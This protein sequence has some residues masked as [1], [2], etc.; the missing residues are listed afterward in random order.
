VGRVLGVESRAAICAGMV[1]SS[2]ER[3]D[4]GLRGED[5]RGRDHWTGL[6]TMGSNVGLRFTGR[7]LK[8][9]GLTGNGGRGI[10]RAV[11]VAVAVSVSVDLAFKLE[12]A[13]GTLKRGAMVRES[14]RTRGRSGRDTGSDTGRNA[15]C[16]GSG[17]GA[18]GDVDVDVGVSV[19]IGVGSA[20]S[21]GDWLST[22]N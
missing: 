16:S 11:A 5:T 22:G 21:A 9:S 2:G 14:F 17:S 20:D 6:K 18:G 19:G 1:E 8:L 3:V 12:Q 15:G 13:I 4:L 10:K 7:L